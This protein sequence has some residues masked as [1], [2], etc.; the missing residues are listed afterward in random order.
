MTAPLVCEVLLPRPNEVH[1]WQVPLDLPAARSRVLWDFLSADERSRAARFR[2]DVDR[3]HFVVA[4]GTLRMLLGRYLACD[5][6]SL[7]FWYGAN[8][9]PALADERDSLPLHFNLSHA[10]GVGVVGFAVGRRLGIDIEQVRSI[11]EADAIARRVFSPRERASLAALPREERLIAFFQ[12]WTLKEALAKATG[13]GL[14]MP[15]EQLDVWAERPLRVVTEGSTRES[16]TLREL[17]VTNPRFVA[18]LCVEGGHAVEATW[19]E[20]DASQK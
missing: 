10:G 18:A 2:F 12:C 3:E 13:N 5:P 9:K 14:S 17:L 11:P 19:R 7:R 6:A 8:G 16:W 20:L 1:V 4:R 15:L